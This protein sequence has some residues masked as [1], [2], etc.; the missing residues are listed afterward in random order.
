[1]KFPILILDSLE[2]VFVSDSFKKFSGLEYEILG[3][4]S[5]SK[6]NILI[7]DLNQFILYRNL[8]DS[9]KE[10]NK[11]LKENSNI[12]LLLHTDLIQASKC[13]I[14][15]FC[16]AKAGTILEYSRG[17]MVLI[18]K[19][20]NIQEKVY[21]VLGKESEISPLSSQSTSLKNTVLKTVVNNEDLEPQNTHIASL[22]S[23]SL[24]SPLPSTTMNLSRSENAS[25][26]REE[27][28]LPHTRIISQKET[29]GL[30]YYS[31]DLL[32]ALDDEDDDL[33]F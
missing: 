17:K 13:Q 15:E 10:L 24:N 8:Q 20:K 1:M 12:I 25:A 33:D 30:I 26:A 28:V 16:K 3:I 19:K 6:S 4:S 9:C 21:Q 5:I 7:K 18:Q 31:H 2:N 14:I 27:L 11:I 23:K 32:D 22:D 29:S